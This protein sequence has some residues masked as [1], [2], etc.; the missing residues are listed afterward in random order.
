MIATLPPTRQQ[1]LNYLAAAHRYTGAI[2]RWRELPRLMDELE[3]PRIVKKLAALAEAWSADPEIDARV[4]AIVKE[5]EIL[6]DWHPTRWTHRTSAGLPSQMV[7]VWRRLDPELT[8]TH[9]IFI[10]GKYH[11]EIGKNFPTE[12]DVLTVIS[13]TH[14]R[15]ITPSSVRA[16]WY[17]EVH[18]RGP[19]SAAAKAGLMSELAS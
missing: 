18:L 12:D 19:V 9:V 14:R 4:D 5:A 16:S 17:T 10:A 11:P 8:A 1:V 6:R 13:Y 7:E 15:G 3:H 2:F